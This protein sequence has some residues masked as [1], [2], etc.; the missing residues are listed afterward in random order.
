MIHNQNLKVTASMAVAT[1]AT[2]ATSTM[3]IDRLGYDQVSV[4]AMKASNANT[5]FAS[6]LKVEE[7]DTTSSYT[8]VPGLELGAT[9][10]F[11]VGAASTAAPSVVKID[12]DCKARKR[13]LRV[14]LTPAAAQN[15]TL[16]GLLS[17][18]EEFPYDE[19]TVNVL[20]W[21]KG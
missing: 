13:Y 2:D 19:A 6:V 18:G 20:K 11:T 9:G 12:V 10:G 16:V 17:R 15:V 4:L 3:T 8:V 14:S 7:G 1:V 21:V 5:N